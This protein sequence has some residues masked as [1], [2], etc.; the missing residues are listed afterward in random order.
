M[1]RPRADAPAPQSGEFAVCG[2]IAETLLP[3][4]LGRA[5]VLGRIHVELPAKGPCELARIGKPH[6][7]SDLRDA[8]TA[9]QEQALRR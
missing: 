6:F 2:A 3:A 7:K 5:A 1:P 8:E 4:V 9:V